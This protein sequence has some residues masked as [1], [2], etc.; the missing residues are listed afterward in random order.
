MTDRKMEVES[1]DVIK[2]IIQFLKENGLHESLRALQEES[3]VT[4]NTVEDVD[5]FQVGF[6]LVCFKDVPDILARTTCKPRWSDFEL[7]LSRCNLARYHQWAMGLGPGRRVD[8]SSAFNSA[9]RVV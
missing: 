5:K 6:T 8:P 1:S 2:L 9:H 7:V 3:Q 4:L